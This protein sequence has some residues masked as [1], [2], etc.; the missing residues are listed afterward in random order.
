MAVTS[1]TDY[2][3]DWANP[4]LRDGRYMEALVGAV[5][6]R[7]DALGSGG[8]GLPVLEYAG[9]NGYLSLTELNAIHSAT[10]GLI[11][12]YIDYRRLRDSWE[13][14]GTIRWSLDGVLERLGRTNLIDPN[15]NL[16]AVGGATEWAKQ[17]RDILNLLTHCVRTVQ[18]KTFREIVSRERQAWWDWLELAKFSEDWMRDVV[19]D[20]EWTPNTKPGESGMVQNSRVEN[21][22]YRP[23]WPDDAPPGTIRG[24]SNGKIPG[25]YV[26][27]GWE[28]PCPGRL[29]ESMDVPA[30]KGV[31]TSNGFPATLEGHAMNDYVCEYTPYDMEQEARY[32]EVVAKYEK[33]SLQ[34]RQLLETDNDWYLCYRVGWLKS[35]DTIGATIDEIFYAPLSGTLE[36]WA[37]V[38]GSEATEYGSRD[39]APLAEKGWRRMDSFAVPEGATRLR[40][41][42]IAAATLPR[43]A[44]PNANIP[45][46]WKHDA[47]ATDGWKRYE[48]GDWTG[49]YAPNF[50][51]KGN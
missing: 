6:E 34:F 21:G 37:R 30:A 47:R 10:L 1:W 40:R 31:A 22:M 41:D 26:S 25:P 15:R 39:Y 48:I 35:R 14:F 16:L 23:K 4:D 11:G 50:T 36:L 12:N 51:F 43:L 45:G 8:A 19:F 49:I 20:G 18:G 3:M 27:L 13:R 24:E 28:F 42:E 9:S 7:T 46:S 44:V 29:G 32:A 38:V 17:T 2:G 5:N 33:G